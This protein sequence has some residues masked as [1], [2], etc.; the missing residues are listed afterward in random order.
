MLALDFGTTD[1][2]GVIERLASL[3]N[4]GHVSW[5]PWKVT[6]VRRLSAR[7]YEDFREKCCWQQSRGAKF[8]QERF[9]DSAENRRGTMAIA[10]SHME[11]RVLQQF[12]RHP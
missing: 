12:G 11:K 1:Y 2:I 7:P 3:I 6:E 4:K 5:T 8:R 10:A 9:D